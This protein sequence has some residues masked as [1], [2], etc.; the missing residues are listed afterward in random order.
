[1]NVGDSKERRI[2]INAA[3]LK[4]IKD[5]NRLL[6]SLFDQIE[7]LT[8]RPEMAVNHW[9]EL[10]CL[11]GKLCDQ[12]AFHFSLEEAYGYFDSA[13]DAA[14]QLSTTAEILRSQHPKLF[15]RVRQ[16]SESAA[17]LK[18][19][20]EDQIENILASYREFS[21]SFARHEEAELN[22]IL[23]ALDDDLGV[24]D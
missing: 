24:G 19:T 20:Q 15:E 11:F 17:G 5:D 8:G 14:P 12:L 18:T 21:E 23:D 3:F 22:L 13:V 16:L 1:M 10:V 6:K 7:P 9:S 4:D 2:T